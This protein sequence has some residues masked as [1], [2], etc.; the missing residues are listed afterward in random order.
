L[1][2]HLPRRQAQ[3]SRYSSLANLNGADES[4]YLCGEAWTTSGI[5]T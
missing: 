3:A 5:N 1:L 4:A 2:V